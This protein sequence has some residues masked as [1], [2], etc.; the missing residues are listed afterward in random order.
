[1]QTIPLV[2]EVNAMCEEMGLV[3]RFSVRLIANQEKALQAVRAGKEEHFETLV[4]AC[5]CRWRV[6][7]VPSP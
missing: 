6:H 4:L 7:D 1:M 2:N 3:Q 5:V